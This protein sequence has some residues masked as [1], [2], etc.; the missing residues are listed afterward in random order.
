MARD[1]DESHAA[2]GGWCRS[3]KKPKLPKA[4]PQRGPGVAELEK[5]LREQGQEID[6]A[7]NKALTQSFTN[8]RKPPPAPSPTP[9]TMTINNSGKSNC[10]GEG[11]KSSSGLKIPLYFPQTW[12]SPPPLLSNRHCDYPPWIVSEIFLYLSIYSFAWRLW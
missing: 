6:E 1:H 4:P 9:M 3:S 5:I 7:E 8:C 2:A 10:G 12:S 11:S